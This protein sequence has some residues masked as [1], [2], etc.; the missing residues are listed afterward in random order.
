MYP[1]KIMHQIMTPFAIITQIN[2]NNIEFLKKYNI[3]KAFR[4]YPL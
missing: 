1:F 4:F 2:K 3:K